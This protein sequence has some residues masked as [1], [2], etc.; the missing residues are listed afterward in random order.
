MDGSSPVVLAFT[1]DEVAKLT[2]MSPS[3][4]R[5]WDDAGF[6]RPRFAG[7]DRRASYSRIYSFKDV[8]GLRVLKLL[9]S[10]YKIPLGHLRD[11]AGELEHYSADPWSEIRLYVLGREVCFREP[12]TGQQRGVLSGQYAL[13]PLEDVARDMRTRIAELRARDASDV[14]RIERRRNIVGNAPVVAG[15]RIPVSA[16]R[17]FADAGYSVEEI[18]AE[19]PSLTREDVEAALRYDAA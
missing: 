10:Q 3:S 16:L 17:N 15:T 12:E 2:G 7:D 9:R 8:V 4:L 1:A 19:Y 6:F 14:G 11:V 5:N 18:M 13:L